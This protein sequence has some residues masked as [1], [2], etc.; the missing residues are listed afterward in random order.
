MSEGITGEKDKDWEGRRLAVASRRPVIASCAQCDSE[1]T[2]WGS[3]LGR[4]GGRGGVQSGLVLFRG[5]AQTK[6][7]YISD[8]RSN[9]ASAIHL[10]QANP[11][12]T[13]EALVGL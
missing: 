12:K 1:G 13:N 5:Q 7:L 6:G 10:E 4:G 9:R 3:D 11:R 2:R 8:L